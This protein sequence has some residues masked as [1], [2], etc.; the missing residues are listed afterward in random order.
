MKALQ[1]ITDSL[2]AVPL[3]ILIVIFNI[4]VVKRYWLSEPLQWTEEISGLLMI[5]I[6][7]I[8]AI[9]AERD[10]QHLTISV[11]TDLLPGRVAATVDLVISTLSAIFLL[12]VGYVGY[13]LADHVTFKV[14]E[15]LRISWFWI[16][17][18]IPVGCVFIAFYTMRRGILTF[19][20]AMRGEH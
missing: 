8:G 19:S 18:A 20:D 11:V 4:G 9:A 13:K 14:T 12:Y 1:R 5:W 15:V 17:I 2:A 7:M 6:V 16:D 10:N 3:L